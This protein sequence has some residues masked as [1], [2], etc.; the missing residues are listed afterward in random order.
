MFT[1]QTYLVNFVEI[2]MLL[3]IF[4]TWDQEDKH[5]NK[6]FNGVFMDKCLMCIPQMSRSIWDQCTKVWYNDMKF[7]SQKS[8][9]NIFNQYD[10]AIVFLKLAYR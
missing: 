1:V 5:K 4:L 7:C 10:F 3:S 8:D 6:H 9:K 2:G